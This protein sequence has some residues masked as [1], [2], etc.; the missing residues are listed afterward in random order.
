[1]TG[2]EQAQDPFGGQNPFG[3]G[4]NPFGG[5]GGGPGGNPFGGAGGQAGGFGDIF[6]EFEKM[7]GGGGQ[8]GGRR[9][10]SSNQMQGQKGSDIAVNLEID[11]MDAINGATK[12]IQYKRTDNCTTCKGSGAK[13][14]T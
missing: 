14:G 11:F 10:G 9:R 6:E 2:D 13:P 5:F 3:Q 1:M 8:S 7:F 4:G 12:T